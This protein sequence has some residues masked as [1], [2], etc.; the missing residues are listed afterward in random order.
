MAF[1]DKNV[2]L[3]KLPINLNIYTVEL[4]VLA[5]KPST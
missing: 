4:L 2:S 1:I 5:I 3:E